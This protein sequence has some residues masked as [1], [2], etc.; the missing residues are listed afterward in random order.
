MF[1]SI[2]IPLFVAVVAIIIVTAVGFHI[3]KNVCQNNQSLFSP[4]FSQ[5]SQ[6]KQIQRLRQKANE[7][8]ERVRALTTEISDSLLETPAAFAI[9]LLNEFK[10]KKTLDEKDLE[11]VEKIIALI[12]GNKLYTANIVVNKSIHIQRLKDHPKLDSEVEGYL[13][14]TVLSKQAES[15]SSSSDGSSRST[16]IEVVTELPLT[17]P[18]MLS[19]KFHPTMLKLPDE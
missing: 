18:V 3:K 4:F 2:F 8:E 6:Q 7:L 5:F 16:I 1:L 9:Q 17:D 15:S 11:N 14:D 19:W 12:A 10:A 13:R